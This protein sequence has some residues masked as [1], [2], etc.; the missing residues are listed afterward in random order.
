MSLL[1]IEL[2]SRFQQQYPGLLSSLK[3]HTDYSDLVHAAASHLMSRGVD[4]DT[5]VDDALT[6]F[7]ISRWRENR[8]VYTV[9]ETLGD[10]LAA[11]AR[12]T[13]RDDRLPGSMIMNLPYPCIAVEGPG[14]CIVSRDEATGEVV[15]EL[16]T[17]GRMLVSTIP[18]CEEAN[19]LHTVLAV[20]AEMDGCQGSERLAHYYLPI[21]ETLGDSVSS[22]REQ[23]MSSAPDLAAASTDDD[24]LFEATIPLYAAQLILYLQAVNAD[25][26]RKPTGSGKPKSKSSSR[27]KA[28]KPPKEYLVGIRVGRTIRAH[29]AASSGSGRSSSSGWTVTPH[30]RR[31][32]WHHFWT[33]PKSDPDKR[34]LVLKWLH[35]TMVG[36]ESKPITTVYPVKGK[37]PKS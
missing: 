8:I 11:Q 18:A 32:H 29:A 25:I 2:E 37:K 27:T 3:A 7:Y 17:T 24:A 16:R 10:E 30:T 23:W 1:P 21:A 33:G 28:E 9:D 19:V 13:D 34:Q 35:P 26:Q 20:L 6:A 14:I 22:L 4:I 36:G 31:G 5:A 15:H 12:T